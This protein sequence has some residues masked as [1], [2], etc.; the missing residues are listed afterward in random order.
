[1]TERDTLEVDILIV[2]GGPGGLATALRLSQLASESE[3]DSPEI[4][5]IEKGANIGSHIISGA[6]LDAKALEELLPDYKKSAP[7]EPNTRN[8]YP[9]ASPAISLARISARESSAR[10]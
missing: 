10:R 4:L 1:M 6:V 3:G 9:R 8:V 7:I 5:L 2:G